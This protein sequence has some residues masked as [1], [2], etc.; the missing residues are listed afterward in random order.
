M[1]IKQLLTSFIKMR[2]FA[3]LNPTKEFVQKVYR[4]SN[5]SLQYWGEQTGWHHSFSYDQN[6]DEFFESDFIKESTEEEVK[7]YLI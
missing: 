2:Y 1:R 5:G 3:H 6:I 7:Q 4:L